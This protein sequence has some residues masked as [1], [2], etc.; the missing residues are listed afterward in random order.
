MLAKRTFSIKRR[1]HPEG[2]RD[3]ESDGQTEIVRRRGE[4]AHKA[5][6]SLIGEGFGWGNEA[7]R[8]ARGESI[9][10]A[11][12][13]TTKW[14]KKMSM[15]LKIETGAFYPTFG[16]KDRPSFRRRDEIT[17]EKGTNAYEVFTRRMRR[18]HGTSV[19]R[20]RACANFCKRW[21]DTLR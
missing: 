11:F 6:T 9:E 12:Y 14:W 8:T 10:R 15:I 18:R 4:D 20:V 3:S 1:K 19:Y 16:E 21:G 7:E 13:F 5:Y 2:Q 17:Q